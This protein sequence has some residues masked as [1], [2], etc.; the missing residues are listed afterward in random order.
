[1]VVLDIGAHIGY[2]TLQTAARVGSRG[3]VHAFEPVGYTFARLKKNVLLNNFTNVFVN[4]YIVHDNC[5]KKKIFISDEKNTGQSSVI[6]PVENITR[7]V[8]IAK[9]IT[10]DEYINQR[11][12]SK[13]D[14]VKIDVEGNELSVLKGMRNLLESQNH[15]NIIVEIHKGQLLS[16]GI[17][18]KE[19]YNFLQKFGFSA[20]QVT[21]NEAP[22]RKR[23]GYL[24]QVPQRVIF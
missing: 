20:K 12:L 5:G 9:C 15:L 18:P 23:T 1:M 21:S 8:E 17:D 10:I 24:A 4:R 3:Q 14:V 22:R 16:Q 6:K 7:R 2:Y 19:V 13:I 11:E